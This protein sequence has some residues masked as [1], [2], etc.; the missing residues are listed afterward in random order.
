MSYPIAEA[1]RQAAHPG[2][3]ALRGGI[4][5]TICVLCGGLAL[6]LSGGSLFCLRCLRPFIAASERFRPSISVRRTG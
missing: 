5:R 3:P 4:T 6:A 1:T 2:K